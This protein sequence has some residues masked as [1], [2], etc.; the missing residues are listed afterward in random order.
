MKN[1]ATFFKELIITLIVAMLLASVVAIVL[2]FIVGTLGGNTEAMSYVNTFSSMVWG[3]FIGY[4]LN[5][6]LREHR[7]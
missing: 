7:R 6:L 4:K 2:M 3:L 1:K 5:T